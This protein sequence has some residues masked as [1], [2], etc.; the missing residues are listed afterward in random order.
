MPTNKPTFYFNS[1]CKGSVL[2]G[3]RG[4]TGSDVRLWF[5]SK[6]WLVVILF[7]A[8]SGTPPVFY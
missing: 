4:Q 7:G 1:T 2:Q 8:A 5:Q 6:V 3:H